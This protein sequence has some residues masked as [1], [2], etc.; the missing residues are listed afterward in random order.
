L[1]LAAFQRALEPKR[2][3]MMSG[4]H[5]ALYDEQLRA[6]SEIARDFLL[7]YLR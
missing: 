4:G 7:G 6:V 1:Q 2:L 5:Y 3:V